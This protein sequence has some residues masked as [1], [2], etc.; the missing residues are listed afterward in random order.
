MIDTG[1]QSKIV[2]DFCKPREVNRV[3]AIKGVAGVNRPVVSR[4]NRG[5]SAKV[6]LFSLG[7]DSAKEL[8]Y[9]RLKI[10]DS[11]AG[12]C[13]FP[14]GQG[15]DEEYFEQLTA[16]KAVTRVRNG[17]KSRVWQKTRAR[18]E[19]LDVRV[20]AL[21]A[22]VNLNANLDQLAKSLKARTVDESKPN[23]PPK[24]DPFQGI[25]RP[26]RPAG[27]VNSWKT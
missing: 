11:G 19:A 25:I 1:Y 27:F 16:E 12:Y 13:H 4:P 17:V 8:I 14:I 2:Y 5:N 20:Y 7:V 22:F 21:A 6:A 3:F 18:N 24:K 9:S 15:Y 10:E 26:P 23:E